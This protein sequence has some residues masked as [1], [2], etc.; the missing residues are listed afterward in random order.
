M[1]LIK[2]CLGWVSNLT[3]LPLFQRELIE[4][5]S[6]RRTYL[7][8]VVYAFI[9]LTIG[10]FSLADELNVV[11]L[12]G[13]SRFSLLGTGEQI[14]R[15]V[16]LFQL[17]AIH[18]FMPIL[19]CGS[20]TSEKERNTL[21]ILLLTRLKPW[22]ILFEKLFGRMLPMVMCL[23]LS[24]PIMGLA[25]SLGGMS[26]DLLLSG[27]WLLLLTT[28]QVGTFT[29]MCSA[30]CGT[31]VSAFIFAYVGQLVIFV[32]AAILNDR[33]PTGVTTLM[34]VS[35]GIMW[36]ASGGRMPFSMVV[37]ES[38]YI[39][40]MSVVFMLLARLFLVRRATVKRRSLILGLFKGLDKFFVK[41]NKGMGDV[42]LVR[43][44]DKLPEDRPI[45]WREVTK[46]ALGQARYLFRVFV[47][48]QLPTM[49][50][51]LFAMSSSDMRGASLSSS[52]APLAIVLWILSALIIT[53]KAST[54]VASEVSNET[55]DVMLTTPM[56]S[57]E[58][59]I[60]K[61]AG[62]RR[63]Q[64]VLAVPL[65]TVIGFS[66]FLRG[67]NQ[68]SLLYA[69]WG[70]L[71][72]FLYFSLI[73]WI[74]MRLGL[75]TNSKN[76]SVFRTVILVALWIALPTLAIVV[77]G[78][79]AD[80]FFGGADWLMAEWGF[81]RR[82]YALYVGEDAQSELTLSNALWSLPLLLCSPTSGILLN[83]FPGIN[84]HFQEAR[85]VVT[86]VHV[87]FFAALWWFFRQRVL[88][89]ADIL[90]GRANRRAQPMEES[91]NELPTTEG[92]THALS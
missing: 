19:G 63:V 46:K 4:S 59:I 76:K 17:V 35:G 15:P 49:F 54:L 34:Q 14:A 53:V 74:A 70:V 56:T 67:T 16:F 69:G 88:Q 68:S 24:F 91:D 20:L 64:V 8:R 37:S 1:T 58:L 82:Q 21:G 80:L 36:E 10:L 45:A 22:R 92:I 2:R 71:Q 40:G 3:S 55:W 41:L 77:A 13:A 12:A 30:F 7:I 57:R 50:I 6:K 9:L 84:Q 83:E 78:K 66:V 29:L 81:G 89:Q 42:V 39:I 38:R 85:W 27:I 87:T 90:L 73:G 62:L 43:D 72:V 75:R 18:I 31:T 60:E 23:L 28:L 61:C 79:V 86:I 5:A 65:L 51:C 52:L 11:R 48:L 25:Y 32:V 26:L 44:V 33:S 47:A